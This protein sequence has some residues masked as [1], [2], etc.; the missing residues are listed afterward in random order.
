[1]AHLIIA[2]RILAYDDVTC[3]DLGPDWFDRRYET[4]A[5]VVGSSTSS[6]ALG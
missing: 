5:H 2:W 6:S 4:R 3:V 1:V